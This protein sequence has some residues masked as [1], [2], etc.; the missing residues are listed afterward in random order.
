MLVAWRERLGCPAGFGA[1]FGVWVDGEFDAVVCIRGLWWQD[2]VAKLPA[3]CG[4]I[5]ASRMVS[6][7]RE[8]RLKRAAVKA[9]LE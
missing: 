7:W 4:V 3:G 5:E 1:P 8:L 6:E 2:G 9:M